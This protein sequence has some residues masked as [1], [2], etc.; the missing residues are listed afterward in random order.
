MCIH[1][2][3]GRS[4]LNA[5][6]WCGSPFRHILS[7]LLTYALLSRATAHEL[8]SLSLHKRHICVSKH[9]CTCITTVTRH[10]TSYCS[11]SLDSA[12]NVQQFISAYAS[13]RQRSLVE[14]VQQ[15]HNFEPMGASAPSPVNS[16]GCD[17]SVR[18]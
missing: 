15:G 10:P 2:L 1:A 6:S 12:W 3:I 11:I 14:H 17:G 18:F 9:C 13:L 5:I 7:D 16:S 8:Q 4:H